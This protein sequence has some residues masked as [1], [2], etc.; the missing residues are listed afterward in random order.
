M[1]QQ[2]IKNTKEIIGKRTIALCSSSQTPAWGA[3]SAQ[4]RYFT[5]D[6]PLGE[7]RTLFIEQ[8][9]IYPVLALWV[10]CSSIGSC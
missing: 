10:W 5:V 3:P 7:A 8:C 6:A 4:I 2:L 1:L 9:Y